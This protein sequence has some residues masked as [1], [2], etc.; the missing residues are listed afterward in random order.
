[1]KTIGMIG[2]GA[3]G[4]HVARHVLEAGFS[5]VLY[6]I[7]P[8]ALTALLEQGAR[9]AAD[10][11]EL[12]RQ[13]DT[14]LLMVNSYAHCVTAMEGL[15]QTMEN[16]VIVLLST[17]SPEEAKALE[18]MAAKKNCRI[19]DCPVS[20]G[21]AGAK[22]GTLTLLVGGTEELRRE[23]QPLLESFSGRVIPVGSRVGDGQAVK[24]INQLLV[25]VHMCAA[26]E[27]FNLARQCGLDLQLVYD[28]IC[29]SAGTSRIFENRGPHYI[30][31][32]FDTRSTLQIQLKDTTIAC[33][34]AEAVGAPTFM[35]NMARELFRL[36]L[37]RY[38][39]TDDSL[40][41]VRL[42]EDLC[43]ETEE[44]Q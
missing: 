39:A 14:V 42:Y 5:M 24:A 7:R 12:G 41:V 27:A 23:C 15:L 3:M 9:A 33:R 34:T 29:A 13:A 28:A 37:N 32:N 26:S 4:N 1:M 6:D 22:A 11:A 18:A 2:L 36:S 30:N 10:T 17:V 43:E 19:L 8:E 35:A 16:G 20:G 25:G 40:S 21:T 38:P 31:R 44:Q